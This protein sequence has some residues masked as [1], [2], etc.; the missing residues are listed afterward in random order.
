MRSEAA[1]TARRSWRPA[2]SP[3]A[4]TWARMRTVS[5]PPASRSTTTRLPS[6]SRPTPRARAACLSRRSGRVL[7]SDA[8]DPVGESGKALLCGPGPARRPQPRRRRSPSL[9]PFDGVPEDL[10]RELQV[11]VLSRLKLAVRRH[12]DVDYTWHLPLGRCQQDVSRSILP[13][14]IMGPMRQQLRWSLYFGHPCL[15]G[16]S[17]AKTPT[18]VN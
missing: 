1:A 11:D 3:G 16:R 17:V 14:Q 7:A 12:E 18:T 9:D 15:S 8:P 10:V 4:Y 6:S 2:S 5:V 13:T